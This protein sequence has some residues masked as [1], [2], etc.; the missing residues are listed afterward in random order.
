VA[1]MSG[2]ATLC[3]DTAEE[4]RTLIPSLEGKLDDDTLQTVLDEISK[5]RDFS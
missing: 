4:A 3:C 5:L 2:L 1:D